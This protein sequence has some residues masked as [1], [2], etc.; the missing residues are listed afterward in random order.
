MAIV[1][2]QILK[3]NLKDTVIVVLMSVVPFGT[4][5]MKDRY[6]AESRELSA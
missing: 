5:W 2:G 4:F 1:I 6:L 3:W